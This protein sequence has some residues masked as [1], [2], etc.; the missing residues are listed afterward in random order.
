[1]DCFGRELIEKD[2]SDLERMSSFNRSG[3]DI[4]SRNISLDL[5][6]VWLNIFNL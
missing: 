6:H 5:R 4:D 2:V 1:L 3:T